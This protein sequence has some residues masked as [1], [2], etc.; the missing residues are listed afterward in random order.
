MLARE[1]LREKIP[2]FLQPDQLPAKSFPN[3]GLRTGSSEEKAGCGQKYGVQSKI[4]DRGSLR[5]GDAVGNK[6]LRLSLRF[7]CGFSVWSSVTTG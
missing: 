1:R 3:N 5:T 6:A 2:R 4:R 7:S